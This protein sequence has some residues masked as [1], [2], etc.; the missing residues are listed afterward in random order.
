MFYNVWISIYCDKKIE[1]F[2]ILNTSLK[3]DLHQITHVKMS[4]GSN[5]EN[6]KFVRKE[7]YEYDIYGNLIRRERYYDVPEQG[8]DY[9]EVQDSDITWLKPSTTGSQWQSD[10][11]RRLGISAAKEPTETTTITA[12]CP[13]GY[14]YVRGPG[15][16][17]LA[18]P[19]CYQ[20][21]TVIPT[22]TTVPFIYMFPR[23]Y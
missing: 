22:I 4:Y 12:L 23:S 20:S 8:S 5:L 2:N 13:H 17:R 6:E 15:E 19:Y 7:T 10:Y 1:K 9:R 18:C 14:E 11:G 3:K 16:V 21:I